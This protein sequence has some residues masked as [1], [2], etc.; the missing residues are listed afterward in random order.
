M[1]VSKQQWLRGASL[2][3]HSMH[4]FR[5][6][7]MGE[8][9]NWFQ[10]SGFRFAGWILGALLSPA[11]SVATTVA[12]QAPNEPLSRLMNLG[13]NRTS[14]ATWLTGTE[15]SHK[16]SGSDLQELLV[17]LVAAQSHGN[18]L[19]RVTKHLGTLPPINMEPDRG[20]L[21]WPR[22]LLKAPGPPKNVVDQF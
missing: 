13:F 1:F 16:F 9:A 17:T 14:Q 3:A 22:F 20:L 18:S 12:S 11:I 15:T 8:S 4:V 10:A 19:S 7:M 5:S 6:I 2:K 21:V